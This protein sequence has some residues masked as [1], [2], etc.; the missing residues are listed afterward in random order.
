[1]RRRDWLRGNAC[2]NKLLLI[3]P[4]VSSSEKRAS[5]VVTS[6]DGVKRLEKGLFKRSQAFE[7]PQGQ[8]ETREISDLQ[9]AT[10]RQ[11]LMSAEQVPSERAVCGSIP[12]ICVY[13]HVRDCFSGQVDSNR[14]FT[15]MCRFGPS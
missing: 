15:F 5:L 7:G 8:H 13:G 3:P 4:T 10:D 12:R 1:M 2:R 11:L 14:L 6:A 9:A